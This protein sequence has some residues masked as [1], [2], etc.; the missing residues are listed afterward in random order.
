[1]S[2]REPFGEIAVKLGQVSPAQVKEALKIQENLRHEGQEHKLLGMILLEQGYLSTTGLIEIL[3]YYDAHKASG[4][5]SHKRS[6]ARRKSQGS[7]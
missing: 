3:K 1:M 6:S 5:E 4:A 7:S 2:G